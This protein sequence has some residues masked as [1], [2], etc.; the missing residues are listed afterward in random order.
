ME[1]GAGGSALRFS[2]FVVRCCKESYEAN[3]LQ[4][5]DTTQLYQKE[6]VDAIANLATSTASDF[7]TV[8]TLT[9][10]NS[11]LTL[12]LIAC[13]LQLVEAL[14]NV[15][16]LTTSLDDINKNH[17][18]SPSITRNWYYCWTHR[19]LWNHSI[20]DCEKPRAGHDKGATKAD[21]KGVSARNKPS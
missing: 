9:N 19:Y 6:T 16:K 21:T 18:A 20:R 11:T 4:E 13:Q 1:F 7:A 3:L 10:T 2:P 15:A 8:S 17:S 14:Q 12:A 5:E